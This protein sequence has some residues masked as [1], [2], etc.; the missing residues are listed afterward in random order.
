LN[1]AKL[2]LP[3]LGEAARTISEGQSTQPAYAH[4]SNRLQ[5]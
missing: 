2:N 4:C 1:D 3:P 5:E